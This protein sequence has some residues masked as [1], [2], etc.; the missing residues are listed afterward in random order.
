MRK[1]NQE[2]KQAFDD[3]PAEDLAQFAAQAKI[4]R[5]IYDGDPQREIRRAK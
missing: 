5:A 1:F 3:L 2:L 4:K